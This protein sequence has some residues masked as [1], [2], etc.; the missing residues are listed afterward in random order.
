MRELKRLIEE[1]KKNITNGFGSMYERSVPF[2]I[3]EVKDH[4]KIK[5][6]TKV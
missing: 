6:E 5:F 4:K 1:A 2:G 3:K